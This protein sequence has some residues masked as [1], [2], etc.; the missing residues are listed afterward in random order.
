MCR[1]AQS[2]ATTPDS[3][4]ITRLKDK[5][6]RVELERDIEVAEKEKREAQFPKPTT[7][8]LSGETKMEGATIESDMVSYVSMAYAANKVTS[9]SYKNQ[10]LIC[11]SSKSKRKKLRFRFLAGQ[12]SW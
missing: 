7:S 5:K 1:R 12:H 2:E 6:T 3:E 8:P 10:Y 9:H 11:L 4:E